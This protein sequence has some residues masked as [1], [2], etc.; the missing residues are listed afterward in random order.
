M[1]AISSGVVIEVSWAAAE[2][3]VAVAVPGA[4]TGVTAAAP[5]TAEP[6]PAIRNERIDNPADGDCLNA[7]PH[8]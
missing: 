3:I 7:T 2:A 1:I 8:S 5:T 6:I 4:V